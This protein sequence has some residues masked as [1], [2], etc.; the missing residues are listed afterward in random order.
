[1]NQP[2]FLFSPH[3]TNNLF[4]LFRNHASYHLWSVDTCSWVFPCAQCWAAKHLILVWI[5][6]CAEI[7]VPLP[8]SRSTANLHWGQPP[9]ISSSFQK[10]LMRP[11]FTFQI[12]LLSFSLVYG[13]PAAVVLDS[14]AGGRYQS[15]PV[16]SYEDLGCSG[17]KMWWRDGGV[18]EGEVCTSPTK[19]RPSIW[20]IHLRFRRKAIG[21]LAWQQ[22]NSALRRKSQC[23]VPGL[24]LSFNRQ[25]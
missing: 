5:Q 7:T 14:P 2:P 1:M 13:N 23:L 3:L 19:S 18:E 12:L 6:N 8:K 4:P 24:F 25:L 22:G 17:E 20:K 9:H 16:G 21:E 11:G 15:V 10:M